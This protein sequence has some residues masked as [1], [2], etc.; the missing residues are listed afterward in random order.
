MR[1]RIVEASRD[2][3]GRLDWALLRKG[4]EAHARLRVIKPSENPWSSSRTLRL[5]FANQK[6]SDHLPINLD[7]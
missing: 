4:L 7:W 3:A 2:C 5:R 1:A 6:A